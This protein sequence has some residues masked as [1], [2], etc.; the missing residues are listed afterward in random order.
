[1]KKLLTI[2]SSATLVALT[3]CSSFENR[4]IA[5][6]DFEYLKAQENSVLEVPAGLDQPDYQ[7]DYKVPPV[8]VGA[9]PELV[10][11]VVEVT[12]PHLVLP[13]VTGSHVTEGSRE[14]TIG[15]DQVDDSQPLTQAI[16]NSL[17]SYLDEQ[18]IGVESFDKEKGVLITDWV[19]A[20]FSESDGWFTFSSTEKSEGK[21]FE[22]DLT[23]KA[24]GRSASLTAKLIEFVSSE[25]DQLVSTTAQG[26]TRRAAE[27]DILNQVIGHYEYQI[28]VE[29]SRR[30]AQVRAGLSSEMGFNEDGEPAIIVDGQYNITWPRLL[31]V[32]KKLG[33]DVKDLDMTSGLMFIA[34]NGADSSWWENLFSGSDEF[35][36]EGDYRLK[37]RNLGDKTSVTF[38]TEESEAFEANQL[39]DVFPAFADV[40]SEDGLDI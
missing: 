26:L 11:R 40:M 9:D 28:R 21:R 27:V 24:H 2:A 17:L 10:G 8:G 29:S 15:F 25:N 34:Y 7:N 14:A 4:Q 36:K 35:L 13:L 37:V 33:F 6:G 20:D 39:T 1:M 30:I 16:W 38:M 22:F 5:S 19:I 12:S 32:L 31:L 3:G 18:N 23:T